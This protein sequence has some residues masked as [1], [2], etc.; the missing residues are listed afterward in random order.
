METVDLVK[1][2][3]PEPEECQQAAEEIRRTY[4]GLTPEELASKTIQ[5]TKRTVAAGG[6][7]AGALANPIVLVPAALADIGT[8]LRMEGKLAGTIAV[9][10]DPDSTRDR[11]AF[12]A[13]ILAV[14]FASTVTQVLKEL[15]E[16]AADRATKVVIRKYLKKGLLKVLLKSSCKYLA[17]RIAR[18]ALITK[19]IPLLG[20]AIGATWNW[21]EAKTVGRR[22]LRY[23]RKRASGRLLDHPN[24]Y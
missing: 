5:K 15:G 11:D 17:I 6:A 20:S 14:L 2:A 4:P 1:W 22:A 9:L 10:L 8:T 21:V 7:A 13:D 23:H 3:I 18:R 19:T 16:E 12:A 24:S